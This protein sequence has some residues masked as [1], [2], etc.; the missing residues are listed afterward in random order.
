[1]TTTETRANRK[2]PPNGTNDSPNPRRTSSFVTD[3]TAKDTGRR[4]G[5]GDRQSKSPPGVQN[6]LCCSGSHE[7]ASCPELQN[8][9]LQSCWDIVK[10]HRLCHVCMRQGHHRGRCES[11]RLCPCG[12]DKRHHRL[13]H[14]PPRTD[15]A[16]T[17]GENQTR[18]GGQPPRKTPT[19]GN[20][21]QPNSTE[22]RSTLQYT[23]MTEPTR[24]KTI[25][26]HV[27]PVKI[28]SSDEKS[29]TTYGLTDK[30]K[31]QI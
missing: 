5:T 3:V 26:L 25:L 28:S 17:N 15:T 30:D 7:L 23:T 6:C 19:P 16:E 29:I 12:S 31:N 27:I 22:A 9:D 10:R 18:E 20:G 8:K 4:L 11:Q 1:M 14:N 24:K 21:A 2:K 13:L